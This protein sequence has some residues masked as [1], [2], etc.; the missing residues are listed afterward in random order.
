VI[1]QKDST[2][3]NKLAVYTFSLAVL[4]LG[5]PHFS[6]IVRYNLFVGGVCSSAWSSFWGVL[7]PW[8]FAW[9][10]YQGSGFV[11][12]LNWTSILFSGIINFLLPLLLFLKARRLYGKEYDRL[13]EEEEAAIARGEHPGSAAAAA[14]GGDQNGAGAEPGTGAGSSSSMHKHREREEDVGASLLSSQQITHPSNFSYGAA[15]GRGGDGDS[16]SA[17]ETKRAGGGGGGS[18]QSA[19]QSDP[20][21]LAA[22][23]GDV[24]AIA[25]G[26]AGAGAGDGDGSAPT[27]LSLREPAWTAFPKKTSYRQRMILVWTIIVFVQALS[28]ATMVM[29]ATGQGGSHEL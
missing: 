8:M 2:L 18:Y 19:A 17:S 7:F 16:S 27:P 23:S 21:S 6:V 3:I 26:S 1:A 9:M 20:A 12:F 10:L 14:A 29:Y 24:T 15:V 11:Q 25:G 4:G 13:M 5:I 22:P 28:F